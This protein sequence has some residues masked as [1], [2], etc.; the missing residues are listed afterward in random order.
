MK[1][2]LKIDFFFYL[3]LSIWSDLRKKIFQKKVL[4]KV[5]ILPGIRRLH[6]NDGSKYD[7]DDVFAK[8]VFDE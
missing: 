2:N 7:D 3:K 6:A 8:E 4:T 5:P 1:L